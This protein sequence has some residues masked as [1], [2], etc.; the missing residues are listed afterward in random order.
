MNSLSNEELTEMVVALKKFKKANDLA[1]SVLEIKIRLFE[2][3]L[4][5]NAPELIEPYERELFH[6]MKTL[7]I[8]RPT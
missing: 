3:I 5:D 6:E 8:K 2:K 4:K 1:L 7:K